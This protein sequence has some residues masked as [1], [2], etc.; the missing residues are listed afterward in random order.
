MNL[1]IT[2]Q[3]SRNQPPEPAPDKKTDLACGAARKWP[4]IYVEQT[5]NVGPARSV[6]RRYD[7]T[8]QERCDAQDQI[9]RV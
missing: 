9:K 3:L 6:L 8:R 5:L 4:V 7:D 1:L 2:I